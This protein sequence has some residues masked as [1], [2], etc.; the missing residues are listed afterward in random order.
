MTGKV[1]EYHRI[2]CYSSQNGERRKAGLHIIERS[3]SVCNMGFTFFFFC[4]EVKS[5]H[6]FYP[7]LFKCKK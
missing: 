1:G 7:L 5:L 4:A 6:L 3:V 2:V